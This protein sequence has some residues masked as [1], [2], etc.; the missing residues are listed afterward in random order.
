MAE[1]DK[2]EKFQIQVQQT[3]AAWQKKME[4]LSRQKE[5]SLA[6]LQRSF[7]LKLSEKQAE[8]EQVLKR[9][10]ILNYR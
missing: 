6:D 1:Y 10:Y 7:E 5:K 8:I 3:K 2:Y 4:E 9:L